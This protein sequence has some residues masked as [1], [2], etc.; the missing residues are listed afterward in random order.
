M[1]IKEAEQMLSAE[2]IF[3]EEVS[4]HSKRAE[5]F[6]TTTLMELKTD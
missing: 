4:K 2:S 6:P 3:A 5:N 1:V